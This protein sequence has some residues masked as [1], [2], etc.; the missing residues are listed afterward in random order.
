MAN[1]KGKK[2]MSMADEDEAFF[3]NAYKNDPKA[4]AA[5]DKEGAA[6]TGAKKTAVKKQAA[7]KK[8]GKK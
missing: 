4:R 6:P 8:G 2:A 5:M 3:R 1:T 7:T